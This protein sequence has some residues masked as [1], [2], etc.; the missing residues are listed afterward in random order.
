MD[1]REMECI[2]QERIFK[3]TCSGK[4]KDQARKFFF[5][6]EVTDDEHVHNDSSSKELPK[7]VDNII[8]SDSMMMTQ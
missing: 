4:C 1:E 6:K 7:L 2:Q 8:K 3:N 5:L